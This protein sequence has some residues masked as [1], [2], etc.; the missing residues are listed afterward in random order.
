MAHQKQQLMPIKHMPMLVLAGGFGTRLREAV[1]ELPKALAPV[2]GK[3]FL[4]H[5]LELWR[6]HGI[7]RYVFLLHHKASDIIA[8]LEA[9][10]ASGEVLRD[11]T[12]S[13][14]LE[15]EPLGTGG[16]IA[17]GVR[18]QN[19]QGGFLVANAD[20]WLGRGHQELAASTSPAMAVVHVENADRYGTVD[21]SGQC[22]SAFREKSGM[23]LS[24]WINAGLYK[25]DDRI[26]GF[27]PAASSFSLERDYLPH[28]V[29]TDGI[30]AVQVQADF[31]DI[32]VPN[33]YRQFQRW[34]QRGKVGPVKE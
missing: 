17:N 7:R 13:I 8:F 11:C 18:E 24:G 3:P 33:D 32:G 21:I 10:Q 26:C 20:T 1:P 22:I 9:E 29:E 14:V 28:L 6:Q 25:L 12:F 30:Q 27:R 16:A 5:M 2:G 15:S 4:A 19:L 23:T 31:I 34:A